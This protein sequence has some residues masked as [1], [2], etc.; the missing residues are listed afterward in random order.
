MADA[1]VQAVQ[2]VLTEAQPGGNGEP[3]PNGVYDSLGAQVLP[4]SLYLA[5]LCE[6]LGPAAAAQIG[7]PAA[8]STTSASSPP[9]PIS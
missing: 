9:K 5:Q 6:R 2:N 4:A 8:C 1:S 3:I 7:Y